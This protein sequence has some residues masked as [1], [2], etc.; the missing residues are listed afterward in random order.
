M[1]TH[2]VSKNILG[3]G[4]L[5]VIPILVQTHISLQTGTLHCYIET[6]TAISKYRDT[7]KNKKTTNQPKKKNPQIPRGIFAF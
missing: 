6:L 3:Y 1:F 7:L 4:R 2:P 5:T